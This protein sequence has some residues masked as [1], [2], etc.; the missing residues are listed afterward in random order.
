MLAGGA[1]HLARGTVRHV[2]IEINGPRLVEAGGS[3][4][5]LVDDLA[6]LGFVPARLARGRVVRAARADMDLDPRHERDCLFVHAT[7]ISGDAR[8]HDL[9][10]IRPV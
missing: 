6:A 4:A 7:A 8:R 5:A 9:T 10:A 2:M 1:V 3:P